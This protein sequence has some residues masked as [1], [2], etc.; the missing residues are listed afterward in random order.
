MHNQNMFFNNTKSWAARA[1]V[2]ANTFAFA[3]LSSSRLVDLWWKWLLQERA[4]L[5]V[6]IF[7]DRFLCLTFTLAEGTHALWLTAARGAAWEPSWQYD[8]CWAGGV[9]GGTRCC[10]LTVGNKVYH[11][12]S[13]GGGKRGE[14]KGAKNEWTR[15]AGKQEA[16]TLQHNARGASCRLRQIR[17]S[18][19]CKAA[20]S[21][22]NVQRSLKACFTLTYSYSALQHW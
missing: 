8:V 22:T 7:K 3:A 12:H 17:N 16:G 14:R 13:T 15:D 20:F 19:L 18:T 2:H 4:S 9:G 11:S 1:Q 10:P 21:P 6:E 5:D